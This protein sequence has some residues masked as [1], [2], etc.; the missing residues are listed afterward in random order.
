MANRVFK[1]NT[2]NILY[3]SW[4]MMQALLGVNMA[5]QHY[6]IFLPEGFIQKHCDI[7]YFVRYYFHE[8]IILQRF[9]NWVA[10]IVTAV[11]F[12]KSI[13]RFLQKKTD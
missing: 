13:Q 9:K 10:E 2:K 12:K 4:T 7:F 3:C 6:H 5:H 8:L 11:C 1:Q